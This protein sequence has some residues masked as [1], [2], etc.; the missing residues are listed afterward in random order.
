MFRRQGVNY[1]G[2]HCEF[3]KNV[4]RY[5]MAEV[6]KGYFMEGLECQTKEV[7]QGKSTYTA[8]QEY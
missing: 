5:H 8:S 2:W 3:L 4:T 6:D 7:K 1:S